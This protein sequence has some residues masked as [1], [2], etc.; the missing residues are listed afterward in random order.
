MSTTVKTGWLKDKNGDK[1]APKT[2]TSQVQTSDG[3]LIED[4]IK[5]DIDTA[6]EELAPLVGTT[7]E[8]TPAQVAEALASG[9]PVAITHTEAP[10]GSIQYCYFNV[11]EAMGLILSTGIVDYDGKMTI[12]LYGSIASG[13]W[14]LV[15]GSVAEKDDIPDAVVNPTSASVGQT[16]VVK[17]VDESGKPTKWES[18]D[19]QPRT[20]WDEELEILPE[21]TAEFDTETGVFTIPII[22][23]FSLIHGQEYIVV[24]N[25]SE[26]SCQAMYMED[27][28]HKGYILGN[29]LAFEGTGDTGHPFLISIDTDLLFGACAPL[30]GST[31]VTLSIKESKPVTIPPKYLPKGIGYSEEK[32]ILPETTVEIDPEAGAGVIPHEFTVEGGKKYNVMYNG[33]EYADCDCIEDEGILVLGNAGAIT[34]GLP[35]TNHPFLLAHTPEG[36]MDENGN[37]IF[38]WVVVPLDG[39]TS[40]TMTIIENVNHT[41]PDKY[42]PKNYYEITVNAE[43]VN[44]R[45]GYLTY[46][47]TELVNA[48][49]LGKQIF[50]NTISY[51]DGAPF[52]MQALILSVN[53]PGNNLKEA[54]NNCLVSGVDVSN[55]PL[56]IM[57]LKPISNVC[58]LFTLYINMGAD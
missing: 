6:K 52:R 9:R 45:V 36:G 48:L 28:G 47:T 46:D 12:E 23:D 39:S 16:I 51:Q 24:Y 34:E 19:Y 25:G 21:T 42:I 53:G 20:H 33:V 32:V 27:A 56:I 37:P 54:I 10:F 35:V 7:A 30:D 57:A 55:I 3:T 8:I 22:P 31:S 29:H 49:L 5:A 18:A 13:E 4:K 44:E 43:Y 14:D 2:L 1:F 11:S 26:Y 40:V 50:V 38:I 15:I 41:I 58:Q 17:E